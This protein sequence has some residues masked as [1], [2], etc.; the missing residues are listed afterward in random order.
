M[1]LARAVALVLGAV[2]LLMGVIGVIT[3][4]GGEGDLLG[5]FGVNTLLNIVLIVIG[6][7][8]LYGATATTTAVVVS[9]VMGPVLAVL[10]L[11]GILLPDG[12]GLVPLGGPNILLHLFTGAV[13]LYI[14]F[15]APIEAR[16]I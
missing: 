7:A 1:G 3:L 10:G 8:L 11:L 6:A 2:Y 15:M 13:L 4:P 9:R 16:A 5:I 12:F 14:G